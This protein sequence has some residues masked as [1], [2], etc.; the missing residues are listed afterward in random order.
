VLE[1]SSL[2]VADCTL[3]AP[4]DGEVSERFV[5][6]GTF[7]H[8]G[9]TV[10]TVIDRDTVRITVSVPEADFAHVAPGKVVKVHSLA[11]DR[12]AEA[13]VS[14]RTPSADRSTRGV[15]VE[16][17]MPNVDRSLPVGTTVELAVDVG[18][19][20]PA[21][22][23][24]LLAATIRG[25]KATVLVVDHGVAHRKILRLLGERDGSAFL[26]PEL[27]PG[28]VVVTE[29]RAAVHDGD[30]VQATVEK[31]PESGPSTAHVTHKPEASR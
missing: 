12:T 8:P 23:V 19:P 29:G 31:A 1:R 11:L 16:L 9:Q 10:L 30:K 6:P 17:D 13:T 24:P 3:R 5:D 20:T 15:T 7:V 26:A 28:S 14:R 25:D 27:P 18:E 2:E 21:L 22:Q 4:F